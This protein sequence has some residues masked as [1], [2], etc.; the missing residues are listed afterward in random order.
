[1]RCN[2]FGPGRP[3]AGT[4]RLPGAVSRTV[5]GVGLAVLLAAAACGVSSDVSRELGA[6]CENV[7]ECD[8]RCL[9]GARFPDGFCSL[10][11]AGDGDCPDGASCVDLEGGVCLFDCAD[12]ASCDFLGEGWRCRSEPERG[13]GEQVMVCVG[14][15]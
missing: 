9:A 3:R 13:A 5:R 8:E 10:T 15:G 14:P 4:L 7:D 12:A 1:M 2:G 6:R 11:C